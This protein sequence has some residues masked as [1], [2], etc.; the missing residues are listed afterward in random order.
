[1]YSNS[2]LLSAIHLLGEGYWNI[3]ELVF[4]KKQN[5]YNNYVQCLNH[6]ESKIVHNYNISSTFHQHLHLGKL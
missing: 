3:R 5:T 2:E 4:R 6:F 1:M